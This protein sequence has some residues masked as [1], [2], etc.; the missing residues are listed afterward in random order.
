M[1]REDF[2]PLKTGELTRFQA[3]L[4]SFMWAVAILFHQA[5]FRTVDN[6]FHYFML[7]AAAIAVLV[8]PS[9]FQRFVILVILQVNVGL[10]QMPELSNH[11]TMVLLVNLTILH[12]LLYAIFKERT[13]SINRETFFKRVTPLV[14]AEVLILYFF[15]VFHK[16]NTAFLEP[17][18]S[19]A[20]EFLTDQNPFG[21]TLSPSL[22]YANA[23]FTLI[24]E[25]AI[26]LLLAFRRT[27][28][29]G[30]FVGL[31]FHWVIAYNPRSGFY[32]FSSLIFALYVFFLPPDFLLYL[33]AKTQ[34]LTAARIVRSAQE[35]SLKFTGTTSRKKIAVM[36]GLISTGLIL[37]NLAAYKVPDFYRYILWTIY[38]V[39]FLRFLI[40]WCIRSRSA[41]TV[42]VMSPARVKW[43][44]WLFP[45]LTFLNGICPYLGLKTEYSFA[46][47]SNLRTEAGISNH[48]F[49]PA[50][51]QIF[52]YQ[53]DMI[54]IVSSSDEPLQSLAD[55]GQLIPYFELNDAFRKG[56][57]TDVRYIRNGKEEY[58]N[59]KSSPRD[60]HL[61]KPYSLFLRKFLDFR[62][63]YKN[64]P[65]P[66]GH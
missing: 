11:W 50:S 48:L 37:V 52:D 8:K 56:R 7:T 38:S 20:S 23:W 42:F 65:Q 40:V 32:D 43:Y 25:A 66:C 47:F 51:I 5:H 33:K 26:P 1:R 36:L 10:A 58:F 22:L 63:I 60:H 57:F 61:R 14:R 16:L 44:L 34:G 6:R 64:E 62:V 27:R 39:V 54:E 41:P 24:V 46:M 55:N 21:G 4:F 3:S 28:N 18:V 9:S 31:L 13:L 2:S 29:I 53:K 17:S 12:V 49:I 30:I 35:W 45:V 15:V 59:R 19:C